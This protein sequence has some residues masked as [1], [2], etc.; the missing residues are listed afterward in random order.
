M[1]IQMD[2]RYASALREALIDHV[3]TAPARRRRAAR[4]LAIGAAAGLLLVAGAAAG[5]VAAG[6]L[7][8]P[9]TPD[10][11]PLAPSVTVTGEG[12][13]TV[14]LG[15][16][17][18]GTTELEIRLACLTAGAFQTADGASLVC[19]ASSAGTG[20]MGWHLAVAAGQHSTVITAGAGERWRLVATYSR[21][22]DTAWGVNAD[23]LTYGVANSHG[24]PDLVAAVAS[25]G[26]VGYVYSR[27]MFPPTPTSLQ[28]G[29]LSEPR[30]IPVYTSDGHTVIGQISTGVNPSTAP[31]STA[32]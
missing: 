21:V 19:D 27:D 28:V 11:A 18:A 7:Q 16:P 24:T 14:E 5:A 26:R 25:N 31:A 23:G 15:A 10:V 30:T 6:I 29:G 20:A 4:R 17:P 13:Q 8:L 32:P 3:Q 22:T 1:T 9:G 12:T 2:D